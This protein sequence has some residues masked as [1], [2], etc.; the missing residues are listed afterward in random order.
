MIS[1]ERNALVTISPKYNHPEGAGG[2]YHWTMNV[3]LPFPFLALI[4]GFM[5]A[6]PGNRSRQHRY[7]PHI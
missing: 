7:A 1:L 4:R 3:S 2:I 6:R 5:F